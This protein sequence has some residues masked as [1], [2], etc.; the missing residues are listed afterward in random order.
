ML[1]RER[2]DRLFRLA[3][4]QQVR[5]DQLVERALDMLFALSEFADDGQGHIGWSN[6]AD[7]S[8]QRIWD[9]EEDTVY[10]NWKD[11]YAIQAR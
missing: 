8:L 2:V 7:S 5:E 11:L 3:R 10:D 4:A 1:S 6:L 9:N